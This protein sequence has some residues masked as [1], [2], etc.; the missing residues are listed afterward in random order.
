M[1]YGWDDV[2]TGLGFQRCIFDVENDIAQLY[3]L[4]MV[5]ASAQLAG[6][7][8]QGSMLYLLADVRDNY[9][10]ETH[11][12]EPLQNVTAWPNPPDLPSLVECTLRG[13]TFDGLTVLVF[14]D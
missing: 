3:S 1:P 4:A 9:P 12:L 13:Q 14:R 10:V 7:R 8:E 11:Y 2:R 6:K 5:E